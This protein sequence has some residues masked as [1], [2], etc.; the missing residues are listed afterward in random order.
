MK[1]CTRCFESY[2]IEGFNRDRSKRD[3]R[4]NHCKPCAKAAYLVNRKDPAVVQRA[5]EK[6]AAW[7]K[8]NP[9]RTKQG[10]RCAT[11]RKKYGMSAKEFD[12]K[13]L[14]QGSCCAICKTKES[15]SRNKGAMHVDHD[16]VS[17]KIRGILC[18]GCNVTLGKM[19]DSPE[20]LR[21]AA[22]YLEKYY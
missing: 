3:G 2:P 13:F 16:H 9:E 7:R 15:S 20:L 1:V 11:L 14:A 12:E 8:A 6:S 10:I 5:R 17:G 19:R 22:A 4:Y 18:Q 21:A